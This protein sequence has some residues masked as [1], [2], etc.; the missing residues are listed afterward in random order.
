MESGKCLPDAVQ[1]LTLCS[2]GN[3][4][5]KVVNLGRYALSLYDKF[6][7]EGVRVWVD[8]EKLKDWPEIESWFLKRKPK[9]EQDT[10]K[11]FDEIE[12]AGD[13]LCS[14]AP[15]RV[16]DKLLGHGHMSAIGLCPVCGEAFPES[17]GAIC[18]GCQGEAPYLGWQRPGV[19][20]AC[21]PLRAVPTAEAVGA[22]ALHDMTRVDPGVSKGV[23]VKAGQ[24]IGAGDV[25][26]LQQMGPQPGLPRRAGPAQGRMGARER[27]PPPPLPGPWP[28]R[29]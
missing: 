18:R 7:G 12:R 4:W 2:V 9:S 17:D 1:L 23:E 11:L 19:G 10:D 24:H 13:T 27:R 25:C 20:E 14:A 3:N 8:A 28:G 15:I 29:A 6:T 22:K 21:P 5:M 26:R 16:T